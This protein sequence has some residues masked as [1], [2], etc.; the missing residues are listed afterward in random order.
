M[1]KLFDIDSP[2]MK[3]LTKLTDMFFLSVLWFACCIPIITIGPATAAMYYITLK[4]AKQE[5]VKLG[6]TFFRAFKE[7]F[8]QGI[9]LNL[10]FLIVGAVL[11]FDYVYMGA[12]EG[13]AAMLSS[14]CFLTM[15]IWWLCIMFYAYPLQAQ[16]FNPIKRTL[17]NAAI[18]SM[19]K[20]V[21]TVIVFALNMLPV[22]V[23]YVSWGLFLRTIPIWIL[24]APGV[25]ATVCGKLFAKL[26]APYLPPVEQEP[27]PEEE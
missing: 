12:I 27:E 13:N 2:V 16:F 11:F 7:N 9:A 17:L 26:F 18:L 4:W 10:I 15:G 21:T 14:M 20:I 1:N 25:I 3:A 8:K 6:A 24:V 19:R 22:I 23:M 5:E